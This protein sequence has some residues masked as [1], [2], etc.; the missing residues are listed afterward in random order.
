ME[1]GLGCTL[2]SW[3]EFEKY[4]VFSRWFCFLENVG[5]LLSVDLRP[6]LH[7]VLEDS[8]QKFSCTVFY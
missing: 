6:T 7:Y 4:H 3:V 8:A 5:G 2:L 1:R